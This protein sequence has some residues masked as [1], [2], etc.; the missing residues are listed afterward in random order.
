MTSGTS[1]SNKHLAARH[2]SDSGTRK[3]YFN[4]STGGIILNSTSAPVSQ[5]DVNGSIS[6]GAAAGVTAAPSNGMLIS[7]TLRVGTSTAFSNSN[8]L[9][10]QGTI[11]GHFDCVGGNTAPTNV[12]SA[13]CNTATNGI[14]YTQAG[15]GAIFLG[16]SSHGVIGVDGNDINFKT[17]ITGADTS[18]GST[19]LTIKS[20]G[21]VGIGVTA[22]T[23]PL[24]VAT[25]SSNA[26]STL[27]VGKTG[28]NKGSCL[29]LFDAAG[30]AVYAY[31][32][33]GASTFTLSA[34]SCK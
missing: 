30:T 3:F 2:L 8:T 18:T 7:G 32:A 11:A 33:A 34:T 17:G 16:Y 19:R 29:E 22:P 20:T 25:S 28:Q 12:L 26:T 1:C 10:V 4:E 31:V 14:R 21:F 24:Q 6:V 23:V 15:V 27:T 13:E 9:F 5:L